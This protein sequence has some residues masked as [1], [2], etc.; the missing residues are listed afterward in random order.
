VT[1]ERLNGT[2]YQAAKG[3]EAELEDELRGTRLADRLYFA[4]GAPRPIAWAEDVWIDPVRI[5]FESLGGAS[6]ALLSLGK[7]WEPFPVAFFDRTALIQKQLPASAR[8]KAPGAWALVAK[9]EILAAAKTLR[10]NPHFVEDKEGPPSRAYLKLW[11]AFHVL[12]TRPTKG[13]T[14][15]DLGSSPGGWTW[16]LQQTGAHVISVDK[17]PLAPHVAKLPRIDF[18]RESAFGLDPKA[19]GHLDWIVSDVIC[20][21]KKIALL[22][23]RWLEVHPKA[24]WVVTI[25]FKGE[26]EMEPLAPLR[27]I[28]GSQLVHLHHNRHEL[29]WLKTR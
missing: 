29:T 22:V 1:I 9:K 27:K 23:L 28:P 26:T 24:N 15:I 6:M 19:I 21:P 3:F 8:S 17:A 11:E 13:E 5:I 12:G 4:E 7:D 25:K 10:P 2:I 20:F 14:A 18:R 16:V